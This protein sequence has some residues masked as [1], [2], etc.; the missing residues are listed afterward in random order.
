M[1]SASALTRLINCPGS[2]AIPQARMS[3]VWSD[4]GQAN[5]ATLEDAIHEGDY[6]GL[7]EAVQAALVDYDVIQA[8]VA[9]AFDVATGKGRELGVGIA[10][11]YEGLAPFEIPGT[12]DL[13]AL[14][15]NKG[16][17][18]I[19][20]YKLYSEVDWV[21]VQFYALAI[22]RTYGLDEVTVALAYLGTGKVSWRT[23]DAF[24]LDVFAATLRDLHTRVAAEQAKVRQGVLPD[25]NDGPWCK[26]CPAKHACPGRVALAR[27]VLDGGEMNA[28]AMMRPLDD[29]AAAQL[30]HDIKRAKSVLD[31]LS[32]AVY[33]RAHEK[34]IPLGNGRALGLHTKLGNEKLDGDIVWQ[35]LRE[36]LSRDV[37]DLAVTRHATKKAIH[38][39]VRDGK[40]ER[41]LLDEVRKR[42]GATRETKEE[43]IEYTLELAPGDTEAA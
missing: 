43:V 1:I 37:A 25:V 34:P 9:V 5:H 2:A 21:Q 12:I 41:E 42:G 22:A 33:A 23:F 17:A 14:T 8:E 20:D 26:H 39:A 35:V 11:R 10:R 29:V 40:A 19:V 38:E 32:K 18:L 30:Y 16:K 27:R 6:S 15:A 13:L 4:E 24:D 36:K 31:Q 28:M 7:P 3:S